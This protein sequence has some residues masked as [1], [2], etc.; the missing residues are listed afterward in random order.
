MQFC[1]EYDPYRKNSKNKGSSDEEESTSEEDNDAEDCNQSFKEDLGRE[2][3]M[4][5]VAP[6]ATKS[7]TA[8]ALS[9]MAPSAMSSSHAQSST[10][11]PRDGVPASTH[12]QTPRPRDG[13]PASTHYQ[14]PV[15]GTG[16]LPLPTINTPSSGRGSCLYP[17]Q[18]P[19][20]IAGFLPP[21]STPR[22]NSGVPASIINTP[23]E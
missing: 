9:V 2:I 22:S 3:K 20:R 8:L 19:A 7:S 14:H 11:R 17:H 13:V 15:L 5:V 10:P 12:N 23:L 18:H 21:S 16:F 1:K 6:S 4:C